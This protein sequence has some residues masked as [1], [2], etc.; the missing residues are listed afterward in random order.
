MHQIYHCFIHE[1]VNIFISSCVHIFIHQERGDELLIRSTIKERSLATSYRGLL[2]S[3]LIRQC[4][5]CL[6]EI[7]T[8]NQAEL[9]ARRMEQ[10]EYWTTLRTLTYF[11]TFVNASINLPRCNDEF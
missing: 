9:L 7:M 11:I 6:E 3:L 10:Y 1:V 2:E 8:V 5:T 4:N